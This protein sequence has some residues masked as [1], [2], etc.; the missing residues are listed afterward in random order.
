[1]EGSLKFCYIDES[2]TGDEPCAVMVGILVDA[3]RMHVTKDNW[4]NLL[5]TLSK[6]CGK[7]VKE[8]HTRDFYHGNGMWKAI[9][10]PKRA[11]IITAI[12]DW[13]K[14]RKHSIVFTAIDKNMFKADKDSDD[15]LKPLKS[16]WCFMGLHIML[17]VQKAFQREPKNKGNTV[18][19]F[20]QEVREETR[21]GELLANPPAW[22]HGYYS[23]GKK[24]ES[25]DQVVDVP[26]YG[27]S[28]DVHLIQMADLT[29]Y[30]IRRY[31]EINQ[32]KQDIKYADEKERVGGW[33]KQISLLSLPLSTRYP[34]RGRDSAAGVFY[35]YSPELIRTLGK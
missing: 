9:D 11:Q 1:M 8:F 13:L 35:K 34:T 5:Q 32:Y 14:N 25:L 31:L 20:D 17:S 12:F 30:F 4:V 24:Q 6:I 29:A 2:G 22:V 28:E 33:M 27:D 26:Y 10:G 15:K 23:R 18:F 21:F 7:E 16:L 19:V 3:Q